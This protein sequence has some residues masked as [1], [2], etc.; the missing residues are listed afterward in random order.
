MSAPV[1]PSLT[2]TLTARVDPLPSDAITPNVHFNHRGGVRITVPSNDADDRLKS[3]LAPGDY[4]LN[5]VAGIGV[6]NLSYSQVR[7]LLAKPQENSDDGR[8]RIVVTRC[9]DDEAGSLVSPLPALSYTP[10]HQCCRHGVPDVPDDSDD[11]LQAEKDSADRVDTTD[12]HA[13]SESA[14]AAATSEPERENDSPYMSDDDMIP[15]PA[16]PLYK[17]PACTCAGC[18][19]AADE[20]TWA[21]KEVRHEI[22][23]L[24]QTLRDLRE[25]QT[26]AE[27][28]HDFK[29][30]RERA[31]NISSLGKLLIYLVKEYL[32]IQAIVRE[33]AKNQ[34]QQE[35]DARELRRAR[36]KA[37]T[38]AL[39]IAR[40]KTEAAEPDSESNT[41][42]DAAEPDSESKTAAESG[43]ESKAAEGT[44]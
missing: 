42:T 24:R 20:P 43:G 5:T 3:G 32:E 28:R 38:A 27:A 18:V 9:R 29:F 12:V 25:A 35:E 44:E 31:A 19:A 17:V 33:R 26:R 13:T 15:K 30:A 4:D 39:T 2:A 23:A 8:V 6:D 14:A 1:A 34:Q 40:T 36:A 7:L 10:V 21:M 37:E 16:E 11:D 22:Q 41:K